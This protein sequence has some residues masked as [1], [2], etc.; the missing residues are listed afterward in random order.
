M[1]RIQGFSIKNY[2][3]L[4]DITI[5]KLWNTQQNQSLTPMTVVIGKNGTGKSSLFDALDFLA[6]CL[7]SGVEE[8]CDAR[9]RGGFD[10]I[11]SQGSNEPIEFQIYYR[12][13]S[14]DRPIT[15]ELV[16][17]TDGT[18][19]PYVKEERL[20]QRR[21]GQRHGWPFSFLW[22][23][24]GQGVAWKGEELGSPGEPDDDEEVFFSKIIGEISSGKQTEESRET[25]VIELQ[26][27]RKLG[28]ATLGALK[29]HPR[30]SE[31]FAS[32]SKGGT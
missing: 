22:M 31:H 16:I 28:I 4:R 17:D 10:R 21:R 13:A 14:G 11:H 5:G 7:K 15:Y 18:R 2:G 29:Q 3:V 19:R 6:D 30:I 26:N 32:S 12:Q 23:K 1:A 24:D 20:R 27:K 8:A 25:E 9:G